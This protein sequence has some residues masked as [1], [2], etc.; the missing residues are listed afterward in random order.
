MIDGESMWLYDPREER[1]MYGDGRRLSTYATDRTVTGVRE[2]GH[3]PTR[4]ARARG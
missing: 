3:A 2:T 4:P 1:W